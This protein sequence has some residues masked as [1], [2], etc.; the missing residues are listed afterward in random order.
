MAQVRKNPLP[1]GRYWITVIS[2]GGKSQLSNFRQWAAS[3]PA[4]V[5]ITHTE[6]AGGG[7]NNG[8]FFIFEI[9]KLPTRFDVAQFGFPNVAG[10]EIQTSADTV[11][12]PPV[13]TPASVVTDALGDVVANIT[14]ALDAFDPRAKIILAGVALFFLLRKND[15]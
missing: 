14:H 1:P 5:N 13:P 6:P 11:Q 8:A 9:V 3:N 2:T 15:R 12:R 10:P 4:R 7:T